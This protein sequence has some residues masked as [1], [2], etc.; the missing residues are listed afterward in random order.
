MDGVRLA[1]VGSTRYADDRRAAAKALE[2]I[3]RAIAYYDPQVVISGGAK[4]IDSM[5]AELARSLGYDVIEHLPEHPRWEPDGYKARNLRIAEGCTH[6]LC[7]RHP[8][9][10]T[11]GSGWTADRAEAM[12]RV[13]HRRFVA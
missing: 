2:T 6:L 3:S 9:S 8:D 10:K 13:V 5:A 11:Y 7:I 12:G 4:G 1:I